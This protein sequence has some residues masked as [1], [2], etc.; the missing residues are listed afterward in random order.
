[1]PACLFAET[2]INVTG[3]SNELE[4]NIRLYVG[5]PLGDD[6]RSLRRFTDS[7]AKESSI[8]LAALGYYAAEI[9]INTAAVEDNTVVTIAVTAND[10][11]HV[12]SIDLQIEGP[13][14]SDPAYLP[15]KDR[16]PLHKG[17][18][19]VS[20]DYETTKSLLID[21]AQDLG[22]FNFVFIENEVR[23]SRLQLTADIR[24]KADSGERFA[25]GPLEFEQDVFSDAFLQRWVPFQEGD[26][27]ESGLVGELTQNLQN[28][29]Y[30]QSVRVVPQRDRRYGLVVPV[31][32]TL[33]RKEDNQVRI[34]LGFATDSGPRT[35][36]TW[37]K[38]T[39]NRHGHSAEAELGLSELQQ[40]LSLS[41]RIPRKNQPLYNFWGIE[42]GLQ[43][44]KDRDEDL[45][46]FLSSLNFQRVSRTRSQWIESLFIRW[47]RERSTIGGVQNTTDLILPGF[48]YSRSRSKGSPFLEWGQAVSFQALYG[49]RHLLSSIDFYKSVVTFKYLKAISKRNTLIGAAQYGAIS[50]NDFERVPASQRFFAG[51]DRSVR[52]FKYRDV[53]PR[54]LDGDVIGG[55]YLEVMSGEYS[56]RFLDLWSVAVFVDAGR[57][58]NNFDDAYSVGAGIGIRWQ[59][60][61]GPF[62]IDLAKPVSDG[63]EDR[64]IRLH[65]SL[66]PDL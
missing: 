49:S 11:V 35:K 10:P 8:A 19:F 22:Y 27:Y 36:L 44:T 17:S 55:R 24:L 56:Y 66:G 3:L 26:P 37:A 33:D 45:S 48:S 41:Y 40:N 12:E 28:S 2:I 63:D 53:S 51:G 5:K 18:V 25:F 23:V 39:I 1:M 21:R 30:F 9:Q 52:G 29:G 34:G 61:V 6:D 43:N 38:P 58:F 50:T 54:N 46:S 13:A 42:Y 7:L 64:G 60:P 15:I 16:L 4:E 57:A 32:V 47:E 20:G 31:K 62:R 14:N 59:S 65:L